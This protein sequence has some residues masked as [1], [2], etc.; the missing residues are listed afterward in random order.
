MVRVYIAKITPLLIEK[1]YGAYYRKI[2][3]WR[4][5]KADKL[6]FKED[7]ARSVGAWILWEKIQ[8]AGQVPQEAV[9]NLSHSGDYVLCAYS[10]A[11]KAQVGCDL[12]E[13]KEL[14][15]SVARRFFGEGEYR[16][17]AETKDPE[18]KT[19]LFYRYWVLKESFMKATRKGSQVLFLSKLGN[20]KHANSNS[21][22]VTF[23]LVVEMLFNCVSKGMPKIQ[24]HTLSCV[25]LVILYNH[26]FDVYTAQDDGRQLFLQFF[27]RTV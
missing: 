24:K 22:P 20:L 23:P 26:P 12:E 6:R 4:Q 15:L 3:A 13:V 18:C 7:K 17:I 16:H 1:N 2:P 19:W 10:D 27:E 5:E 9:F 11:A 21:L 8:K 14:R 25:I